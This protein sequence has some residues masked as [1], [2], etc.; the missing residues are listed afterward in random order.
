MKVIA[1]YSIK[2]GVGKTATA[3]NLAYLAAQEQY[4]TILIDMDPQGSA[5][6]YFRVRPKKK[7]TSKKFIKGTKSIQKN[8]RGTDYQGLDSLPS[9]MTFRKMDIV[10]H[11]MKRSQ[12]R[13]KT[14]LKPL[15]QHYDLI[16]I[17]SP[18]NI[19]LVSENIIHAADILLV[20]LIPTPLSML[21]YKKLLIF[22]GNKKW[23]T[24]KIYPFFSM[25]EAR[26]KIHKDII[27]TESTG[28]D[29]FL[30]YFIPY[31]AD[32][33]RMGIYRKPVACT[34]PRSVAALAY[35]DLWHEIKKKALKV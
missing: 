24:S 2:G 8:I 25:V 35:N 9:N 21:T 30:N 18:P 19:T 29:R 31:T 4:R 23:D 32:I 33:E 1:L 27:Q 7:L 3:V 13:L 20:P 12:K 11:G 17:D 10:L 14:I 16:F 6:Y 22:F 34:R 15:K 5:S 28:D 26:K